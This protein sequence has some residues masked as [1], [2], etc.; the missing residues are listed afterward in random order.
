MHWQGH[1]HAL[2]VVI[3]LTVVWE[4]LC[5]VCVFVCLRA[6][7]YISLYWIMTKISEGHI[8]HLG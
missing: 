8:E 2:Y 7:F 3:V 6:S 5:F 4:Y 1:T